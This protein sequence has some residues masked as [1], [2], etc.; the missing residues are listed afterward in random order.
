MCVSDSQHQT[1]R[2]I[3]MALRVDW[4]EILGV[5]QIDAED[6][7]FSLGGDSIN[8]IELMCMVEQRWGVTLDQ[9]EI[10]EEPTFG[11][12]TRL[13]QAAVLGL[14]ASERNVAPESKSGSF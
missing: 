6:D 7:F 14:P 13:V 2:Q 12:F 1:K 10:V 4:Q 5:D 9:V 11:G 8:G 3:E